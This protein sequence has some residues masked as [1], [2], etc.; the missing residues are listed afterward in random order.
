[1][2]VTP[3]R[4][5]RRTT[6]KY[7]LYEEAVQS[8]EVHIDLVYSYHRQWGLPLP[9]R[10]REDFCGT[11]QIACEWVKRSPKN[12][13]LGLDLDPEPLAQGHIRHL[14]RLK[15]EARSRLSIQ[16]RDVLS[17][18]RDPLQDVIVAG[19]FSFNIFKRRADLLEYF[20]ACLRSLKPGGTLM[21]EMAGGPGM[22]TKT[23]ERKTFKL[24]QIKYVYTWEQRSFDPVTGFGTY[25]IH[26][27]LP[28]G[29]HLKDA[30]VY[31]WRLWSLTELREALL[32]A[33]FAD[34]KIFWE[35]ENSKEG[36]N[37][38]RL[39]QTG[40]NDHSFIAYVIGQRAQR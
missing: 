4:V 1:M 10:L 19:N 24:R 22:I 8:P 20:R 38:Y 40:E 16:Q 2:S 15:D 25:A 32:E 5:S 27:K 33:G 30:F 37:E 14:S 39:T 34:E 6:L 28:N 7:R 35:F 12:H 13:A 23:R 3:P 21:L 11:F 29:E 36:L 9:T 31:D 18:H 17:N 26:F